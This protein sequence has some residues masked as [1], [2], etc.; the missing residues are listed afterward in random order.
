MGRDSV[1]MSQR[2]SP[3][4][5]APH[6]EPRIAGEGR[7]TQRQWKDIPSIEKLFVKQQPGNGNRT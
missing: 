5:F 7:E 6:S 1:L 4:I 2:E 3:D